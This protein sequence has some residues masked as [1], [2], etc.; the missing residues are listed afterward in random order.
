MKK[1]TNIKEIE[2]FRR[3]VTLLLSKYSQVEIAEKLGMDRANFNNYYSGSKKPGRNFLNKFNEVFGEEVKK[4]TAN[5]LI[6]DSH[7]IFSIV[8]EPSQDY[9]RL[10]Y[11]D[12]HIKTLKSHTETLQK[13][14]ENYQKVIEGNLSVLLITVQ[15]INNHQDADGKFMRESLT[16]LLEK[17]EDDL[18]GKV[19]HSESGKGKKS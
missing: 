19:G 3:D 18:S 2:T 10:D 15:S 17:P 6:A 12:D 9:L 4:L 5:T 13:I 11:R 8:E 1:P 7:D 14:I 16:I